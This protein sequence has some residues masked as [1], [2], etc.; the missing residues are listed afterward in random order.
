MVPMSIPAKAS[1]AALLLACFGAHAAPQTVLRDVDARDGPGSYFPPVARVSQG[2]TVE[3]IQAERGWRQVE[4]ELGRAWVPARALGELGESVPNAA[5]DQSRQNQ[6]LQQLDAA[7]G[8]QSARDGS[9]PWVQ[10]TAAVR[11]FAL[12]YAASRMPGPPSDKTTSLLRDIDVA[13]YQSF[14]S[15]RFSNRDRDAVAQRYAINPDSVPGLQ[16]DALRL[17]TA[18]GTVV[19]QRG[20]VDLPEIEA[21]LTHVATLVAE[22]SHVFELPV[23]VFVLKQ[24]QP[25]G[26]ITPNGLLFV[27][28]GALEIMQDEAE[29]AFFAGHEIAHVALAHGRQAAERDARRIRESQRFDELD[30]ELG[31][32]DPNSTDK[33]ART[34]RELSAMADAIYEVL[35]AESQEDWE[36]EA[37]RW[38]M[39]YAYRAG[40]A[41]E[42]AADLLTRMQAIKAEGNG[43]ESASRLLWRQTPIDQ[44][45]ARS[46]RLLRELESGANDRRYTDE[47]RSRGRPQTGKRP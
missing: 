12:S 5:D 11:G 22:S 18:I 14:L 6:L 27:S 46:K 16:D 21:Y 26:F 15:H 23:R 20:T 43:V 45:I 32:D 3:A 31:W 13:Q 42:A 30:R 44:R 19:S 35:R 37:D 10:V 4:L 29:F 41:P 25:V 28:R 34:A 40:Y 9:I 2:T 17:G 38:G 24:A 1:V 47:F 33:Y 39:V 7:E 36:F 8:K